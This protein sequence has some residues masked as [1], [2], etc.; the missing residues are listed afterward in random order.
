MSSPD[1][2]LLLSV[3]RAGLGSRAKEGS[4]YCLPSW[5]CLAAF[6]PSVNL[7]NSKGRAREGGQDTPGAVSRRS[8]LALFRASLCLCH[9]CSRGTGSTGS[10]ERP[11][12][13]IRTGQVQSP[14][15]QGFSVPPS[16]HKGMR[17]GLYTQPRKCRFHLLRSMRRQK[18]FSKE[19]NSSSRGRFLQSPGALSQTTGTS[20]FRANRDGRSD[21]GSRFHD[22]PNL[23]ACR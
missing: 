15:P 16:L 7:L 13:R 17:E 3:R 12:Q 23:V 4:F 21:R 1:S 8:D 6:P 18:I 9:M 10:S 20:L 2:L 19:N 22:K 11:G 5:V 14:R